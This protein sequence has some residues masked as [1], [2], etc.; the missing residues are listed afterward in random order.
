MS[1]SVAIS[2]SPTCAGPCATSSTKA[3]DA[4]VAVVYYAGH[5]IEVDGVNYLV[6]VDAV[7]D[8]TRTSTTRRCRWSAS[9]SRSNRQRSCGS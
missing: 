9:S 7:L 8:V 5:G 2:R 3:R 1:I 6:P 4:D